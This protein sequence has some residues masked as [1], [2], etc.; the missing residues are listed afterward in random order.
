MIRL[1]S[2]LAIALYS[3]TAAVAQPIGSAFTYQGR[4]TESGLPAN[5]LYDLQACL[6]E[7]ASSVPVLA[8]A[9]IIDDVPVEE[10]VFT[11]TLDFGA[12]LF[13][14]QQRFLEL[15]V[16]P[17][18][19]ADPPVRLNPRQAVRAVPEALRASSTPWSGVSAVPAGFADG[20]DND[21]GGTVTSISAGT[22]LS[23]GTITGNGTIAIATGGVGT[24]QIAAGAVGTAQLSA[25]AV[26]GTQLAIDAVGSAALANNAVDTS[27]VQNLAIT[28]PKIA[29]GAVGLVQIDTSQVQA[30]VSS[31]CAI[32]E[33]LRGINVDG[34]LVCESLLRYLGINLVS[35]AT[36]EAGET[37]RTTSIAVG[38]DGIPIIAFE[39]D[40]GDLS[41]LYVFK[42]ANAAC[43]GT[44][45]ITNVDPGNNVG[46]NLSIAIGADGLPIISYWHNTARALKV[47]KCANPACTGAAIVTTVDDPVNEVGFSSSIAIGTDGLPVISYL[48]TTAGAL[49]VARCANPACTGAATIT[50]VEDPTNTVGAN[51]DIVIGTDGLPVISYVD[52]TAG[53]LKVARC[54]NPA[55][56][57]AATITTV[58]DPSG[59]VGRTSIT[60]DAS[61]LPAIS[62][63]DAAPQDLRLARCANPA[64]TGSAILSIIDSTGNAGAESSIATLPDGRLVF[65]YSDLTTGSLKVANCTISGGACTRR[66]NAVVDSETG[67]IIGRYASIAIGNDGLPVI[68]YIDDTRV[69]VRVVKCGTAICR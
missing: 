31:T 3:I 47:A 19:S 21:S 20:V 46:G 30:R 17:G 48:D 37:G 35:I 5:G 39:S 28:Q 69:D 66:V 6:F 8:C 33:Y 22:G 68:S 34:S 27:A 55:C 64:C 59:A 26:S 57:G 56:T 63:Y 18:A 53:A 49:K 42:C 54:A 67:H 65:A 62:Y 32:G 9:P 23:G 61:G 50:T 15:G 43:T 1:A 7:T 25:G 60:L 24:A 41:R 44:A 40:A 16:R 10:G 13:S 12:T 45:T 36:S 2:F 38:A 58:H 14:G 11:I 52:T 29:A 51:S 4:L